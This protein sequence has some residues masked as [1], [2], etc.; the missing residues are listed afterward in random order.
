MISIFDYGAGN[1]RSVLNAMQA[2]G[3]PSVLVSDAI[4]LRNASKIVLPGVGNF[5]Q[6]MRSIDELNVRATLLDRIS[7]GV[8]FL[9]I[10][11]GLQAL[12]TASDEAPGFNGLGVLDGVITRFRSDVRAPHMGWNTLKVKRPSPVLANVRD[13]A[14]FYF[15]HS[16]YASVGETTAAVT[17][18]SAECTAVLTHNNI[19]GVQFHPEKSGPA[20][21]RILQNFANL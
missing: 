19:Y 5:G 3:V 16:Y 14:W 8:P 2:I 21:L 20:G 17:T 13:G 12:F 10:C 11:L 18:Y 1:L 15:A 4:G 6:M 7:S 9:G